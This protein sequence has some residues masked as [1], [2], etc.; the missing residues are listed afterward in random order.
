MD[1]LA[2]RLAPVPLTETLPS[3]TL[4]VAA[5]TPEPAPS[6]KLPELNDA[7]FGYPPTE[8]TVSAPVP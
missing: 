2:A 7:P 1:P 5:A 6:V 4:T 8:P 3:K